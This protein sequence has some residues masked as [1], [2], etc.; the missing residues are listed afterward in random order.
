MTVLML[1]W[2]VSHAWSTH[3]NVTVEMMP[4]HARSRNAGDGTWQNACYWCLALRTSVQD[5]QVLLRVIKTCKNSYVHIVRS[6]QMSYYESQP[7]GE[8]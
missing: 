2:M 4:Q 7:F 8:G 6:M 3:F 5:I 1:D